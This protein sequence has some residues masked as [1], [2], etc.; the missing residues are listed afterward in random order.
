MAWL[1][2]TQ[3]GLY[4]MEGNGYS[5]KV[6]LRDHNGKPAFDIPFAWFKEDKTL[7]RVV[8]ISNDGEPS[9]LPQPKFSGNDLASRILRYMDDKGYEIFEGAR[10]YNI[11]Y[12]EGMNTN[13]VPN[14]DEFN[15][16]NDIRLVIEIVEGQPK[17]VGG[18]WEATTEPGDV[19]TDQ[20]FRP[21]GAARIQFGQYQAWHVG[22]HIDHEGLIQ[23]AGE[24]SVCRDLNK[25]GAR[26]ND[27][28]YTGRFE[29]NQH[30]GY[31]S[32]RDYV[33]TASA[34]CLVGRSVKEHKG[35][36]RLIKQDRRYIASPDFAFTTTIIPGNKLN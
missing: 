21:E 33:G 10:T 25:D 29:I 13:G 9:P 27:K 20:P 31:D 26:T 8:S 34:G 14:K 19:Y 12:V 30:H 22:T 1:Q 16:F 32:S 4:L 5:K 28:V 2:L 7:P 17:I 23:T 24:I 18:P 3:K 6:D 36:M 11:V 35:F 15:K